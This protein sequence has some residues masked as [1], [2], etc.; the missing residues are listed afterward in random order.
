MSKPSH[1]RVCIRNGV[2]DV[3]IAV[4]FCARS[5]SVAQEGK[6]QEGEG[7]TWWNRLS[8]GP[9]RQHGAAVQA[10]DPSRETGLGVVAPAAAWAASHFLVFPNVDFSANLSDQC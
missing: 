6:F 3:G 1:G 8:K 5:L 7:F 10:W 9:R 2:R 4:N